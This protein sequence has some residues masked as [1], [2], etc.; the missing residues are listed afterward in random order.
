MNVWW[1]GKIRDFSFLENQWSQ[2][3]ANSNAGRTN[4]YSDGNLARGS[5]FRTIHDVPYLW[6]VRCNCCWSGLQFLPYIWSSFGQS[7]Q[8]EQI[9]CISASSDFL[10]NLI[11]AHS[12]DDKKSW[13]LGQLE[14]TDFI[15]RL[16]SNAIRW[17]TELWTRL[18]RGNARRDRSATTPCERELSPKE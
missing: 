7:E 9:S 14:Q 4:S 11:M 1:W 2:I 10:P 15:I 18:A 16:H 5:D 13:N 12:A 6:H 8:K 3:L 17:K